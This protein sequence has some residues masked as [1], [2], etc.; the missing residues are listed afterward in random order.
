MPGNQQSSRRP[1]LSRLGSFAAIVLIFAFAT[2]LVLAMLLG[3]FFVAIGVI[4]LAV[5]T[6]LIAKLTQARLR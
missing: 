3:A 1:R 2:V 4:A 6:A 5:P